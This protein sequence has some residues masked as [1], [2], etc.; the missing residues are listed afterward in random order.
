MNPSPHR[1]SLQL[2]T[3]TMGIDLMPPIAPRADDEGKRDSPAPPACTA[4]G[5]VAG[6]G[7]GQAG[8]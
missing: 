1:K 5:P 4:S 3:A 7:R 8:S 6:A 2:C